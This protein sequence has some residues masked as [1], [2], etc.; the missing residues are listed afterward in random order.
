[1][2]TYDELKTE[3]KEHNVTLDDIRNVR[4]VLKSPE[5]CYASNLLEQTSGSAGAEVYLSLVKTL[6]LIT[7][8]Y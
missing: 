3:L 1:M 2:K 6:T 5:L 8:Q 4:G 7:G